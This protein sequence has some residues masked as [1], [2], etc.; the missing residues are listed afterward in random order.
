MEV[1]VVGDDGGAH[2]G[3]DGHPAAAALGIGNGGDEEVAQDLAPI[4]GIGKGADQEDQAHEHDQTG[5]EL[6]DVL[7]AAAEQQDKGHDADDA[8]EDVLP[9]VGVE[10]GAD[11][12]D[13]Q[14]GAGDIAGLIGHVADEDGGDDQDGQEN[15]RT[16]TG[17]FGAQSFAEALLGNDTQAGGHG[18]HN[19]DGQRGE[20]DG[21]QER[22]AIAGAGGEAGSYGAGADKRRGNDGAGA[23]FLQALPKGLFHVGFL[24]V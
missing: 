8:G 10:H 17:E 12:L 20:Q 6:L 13:A 16:G 9:G 22:G 19:D 7:I 3:S 4:V 23:N 15:P 24:L 2:Q 11:G 5:E 18:L 14:D 21:P 1:D